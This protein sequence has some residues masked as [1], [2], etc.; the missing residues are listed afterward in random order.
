[1]ALAAHRLECRAASTHH[2]ARQEPRQ[3][4]SPCRPATQTSVQFC[5]DFAFQQEATVSLTPAFTSLAASQDATCLLGAFMAS[6]LVLVVEDEVLVRL[7]AI[8]HLEEAGFDTLQ[9]GNADEA[10]ALLESREDV[11][12][13]FTDIHMPGSMDGLRLAHAVRNRWPPIELVVTSG[14]VRVP[15]EDLPERGHFL[16]KPYDG[17]MLV[18]KVQSL[19]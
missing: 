11:T 16:S 7:N 5:T 15:T 13:V 12:V 14:L 3:G 8:F 17:P 2:A 19:V 10:I 1:M 6:P 9:A 4:R 18:E